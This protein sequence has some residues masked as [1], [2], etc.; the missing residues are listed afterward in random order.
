VGLQSGGTVVAVG[1]TN[2]GKLNV[3]GWTGIDQVA[4]GVGHTVGLTTGST[5][6]AAGL[7]IEISKWDLI[8]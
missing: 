4:A 8:P 3:G 2:F 7:E 6:V 5:V 1:G